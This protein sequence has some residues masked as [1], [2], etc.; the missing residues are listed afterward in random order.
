MPQ[1]VGQGSD[2]LMNVVGTDVIVGFVASDGSHILDVAQG[3]TTVYP[4]GLNDLENGVALTEISSDTV[5]T[6]FFLN[7]T[8]VASEINNEPAVIAA[9]NIA[10]LNASVYVSNQSAPLFAGPGNYVGL[11]AS[12]SE[13]AWVVENNTCVVYLNSVVVANDTTG[14]PDSLKVTVA[15]S[16]LYV[17]WSDGAAVFVAQSTDGNTWTLN[18]PFSGGSQVFGAD[19]AVRADGSLLIVWS[20]F[21]DGEA[22]S[23]VWESDAG[24]L[25]LRLSPPVRTGFSGAGNPAVA[26]DGSVA[27]LDDVNGSVSGHYDVFLNGID[28]SN[29]DEAIDQGPVLRLLP[30]GTRVVA[31]GDDTNVWIEQ[32]PAPR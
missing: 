13:I 5:P 17:G 19:Y 20:Q 3:T 27:W 9:P 30:N 28:L 32:L 12:G 14:C 21:V 16:I 26:A 29:L 2:V 22:G 31:W 18:N 15:N 24:G 8:L 10:W 25:P 23:S 6:Q 11:A 7:G 4:G 1:L